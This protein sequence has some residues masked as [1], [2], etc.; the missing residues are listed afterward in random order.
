MTSNKSGTCKLQHWCLFFTHV[1]MFQNGQW[2]VSYWRSYNDQ[3]LDVR[4]Q[5]LC[6]RSPS[7][8]HMGLQYVCEDDT[9]LLIMLLCSC[10]S[11][12]CLGKGSFWICTPK[13]S[14]ALKSCY[15]IN[16][17]TS[18]RPLKCNIAIICRHED[19]IALGNV[20]ASMWEQQ[21]KASNKSEE[22]ENGDTNN[23]KRGESSAWVNIFTTRHLNVSLTHS[24]HL[25]IGQTAPAV[26]HP[27]WFYQ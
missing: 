6:G 13:W 22:Q 10:W 21:L 3:Y 17:I 8:V 16:I 18:L 20:Y 23:K 27:A 1:I 25:G 2:K 19:L 7:E 15:I 12:R 11:Y 9:V 5:T 24:Y 4:I 14:T 26:N